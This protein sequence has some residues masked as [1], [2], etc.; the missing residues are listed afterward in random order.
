[1]NVN[2]CTL[3]RCLRILLCVI[4][5]LFE[6]VVYGE[7]AEQDTITPSYYENL[8]SEKESAI[9]SDGNNVA[10]FI[11]ITDTHVQTNRM[12]APLLI[13]H[14][15]EHTKIKNVIWGGDAIG[16][17]G[18]VAD[19]ETQWKRHALYDSLI[20]QSGYLYKIR[21]NHDF[22]IKE[23]SQSNKGVTYS[24]QKTAQLLLDGH[25]QN[26]VLNSSDAG[27]CYYYFDDKDNK[28]RFI[29]FD[30]TDSVRE[31]NVAWGTIYGVHDTQLQWVA[32]SAIATTPKG[33]GII[34]LSHVPFTDTTGS[35]HVVLSNVRELVD[36]AALKTMGEIGNVKYDFT[37]LKNVKVLMCL[38]GHN[39][40]DMQTFRNGVVH[41]VTACDAAYDDYKDDPFVRDL[42]GMKKGTTNEQCFD[43]ITI[44]KKRG[45]IKTYRIGIGGNRVFH[46]NPLSYRVGKRKRLKTSLQGHVEWHSYNASRNKYDGKWTLFNDV[47]SLDSDGNVICEKR[48]ESV[49]FAIDDNGNRE[50]YNIEVK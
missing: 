16:A 42:S 47:V 34:F 18:T 26:I 39:H 27:A 15:L 6:I 38:S 46:T 36:A 4:A 12:Q 24:Q 7:V 13:K 33:Y 35:R 44:N 5:F 8:L 32:D 43:C 40:Q 48:G 25:P 45:I 41:M 14:L 23:S 21:G 2:L 19:I 9:N 11:F 22:T 49:V 10:S 37:K 28:L 17:Y 31:G 20:S 29:V 3:V 30:T 50:F 1:M